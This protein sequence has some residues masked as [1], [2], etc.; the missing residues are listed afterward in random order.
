MCCV[1]LCC[2]L[3]SIQTQ[4]QLN[5]FTR[6]PFT[7][8]YSLTGTIGRYFV[9]CM[10][11]LFGIGQAGTQYVR[12]VH[13]YNRHLMHT[14]NKMV[15][16]NLCVA[17]IAFKCTRSFMFYIHIII[18][19]TVSFYTLTIACIPVAVLCIVVIYSRITI[20]QNTDIQLHRTAQYGCCDRCRS[21]FL[22]KSRSLPQPNIINFVKIQE[23]WETKYLR[24][25]LLE[26]LAN[27]IALLIQ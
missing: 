23:D 5:R 22:S 14:F 2:V 17:M 12:T 8:F 27:R 15:S 9:C 10:Y 1:V 13:A 18:L 25:L 24:L 11:I 4:T 20:V 16:K 19:H 3:R 6:F 26:F 7:R 21:D